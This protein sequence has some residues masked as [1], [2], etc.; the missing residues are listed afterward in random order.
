MALSGDVENDDFP[1]IVGFKGNV[2]LI[3]EE[4]PSAVHNFVP[5]V[6][7]FRKTLGPQWEMVILTRRG[8]TIP[9]GLAF[10]NFLSSGAIKVRFLPPGL[11]HFPSHPSVSIFLTSPWLWETF[12][13][14]NR[15]LIF[16][17]DSILCSK[18]NARVDDFLEW[19]IIG[20][21]MQSTWVDS[22]AGYGNYEAHPD[23]QGFNGGLCIRNP[24]LFLDVARRYNF[25]D[26]LN[27][28][29]YYEL[30]NFMRFEDHW[31][32][33]KIEDTPELMSKVKLP[34]PE[35]AG[36]FS[37]ETWWWDEPLGYH[38]P[39]RWQP[40]R[41]DEI[42]RWCPEVGMIYNQEMPDA[43]WGKREIVE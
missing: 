23:A 33:R 9:Q 18:S 19:D 6:T 20:A 3:M 13:N 14:V 34:P 5:V 28:G 37:V 43:R 30:P 16:Q 25:T 2:A 7:H 42:I 39:S 11:D 35:I 15:L 22:R 31:F 24:R 1:D 29:P 41:Y 21:P 10:R 38:Q 32:M 8:W 12:Q 17:P 27:A 4:D 40:D 26:D 36:K